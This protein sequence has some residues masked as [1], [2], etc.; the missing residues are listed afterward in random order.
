VSLELVN[1]LP[2]DHPY[3]WDGT[4]VGG[5]KLWRPDELGADLAVWLDAEDTS[6]ITLNG[7]TVSQWNDKSGNGRHVSQEN[8]TQQPAYTTGALSNKPVLTFDGVND[9]LQRAS[10][11][12]SGLSSVSIFVV[13]RYITGGTSEDIATGVGTAGVAGAVRSF[14]RK[15]SGTTQGWANWS[16]DVGDSAFSCDIGGG[17][18]IF[19][20]WNTS[21]VA[22]NN[23][24]IARDG[25]SAVYTNANGNL[26]LT[27]DG[28]GVGELV[29]SF[30][31]YTNASIAEVVILPVAVTTAQQQLIEGY[32]AHKWGLEANLPAGHPYKSTPPYIGEPPYVPVYDSDAQAYFDRVEGPAGDNQPLED[33]VKAAINDFVVGCKTDGIWNAI[34]SSAILAGAR[35]L[36][37]ALQPLVGTPPTN[38]NFV[39]GDYDRKTGLVGDRS[40]KYLSTNW[41]PTAANQNN[42]HLAAYASAIDT[43]NVTQ[44]LIGAASPTELWYGGNIGATQFAF[45]ANDG[46]GAQNIFTNAAGLYGWSRS[47]AASKTI[48]YPSTSVVQSSTSN[49][50][51]TL[52]VTVFARSGAIL[53][54]GHRLTFFTAGEALDLALL[55][56][57]VST[58]MTA[59]EFGINTGLAASDYDADTVAYV[60]RGYAAGGSLS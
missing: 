53:H 32:L 55:D 48:R 21:L 1:R 35:T 58:L 54:G 39:S 15:P 28:L 43:T 25:L 50:V 41:S 31:R 6:T 11:G 4:A 33:A 20:G 26:A 2:Y 18:H 24:V 8:A 14:Y 40:T 44:I 13:M 5:V 3:R 12:L 22:G 29:G 47:A 7:S 49:G 56:A 52:A 57:R 17:H 59:L 46:S 9:T 37:G 19:A 42:M 10:A 34:K 38:F 45:R 16:R 30:T 51:S 27:G 60:N 23:I 36:S